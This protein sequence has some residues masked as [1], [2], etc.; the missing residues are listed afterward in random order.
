MW[1]DDGDGTYSYC[2]NDINFNPGGVWPMRDNP[3]SCGILPE[4]NCYTESK[5]VHQVYRAFLNRLQRVFSGHPD[6]ITKAVEMMEALQVHAKK[7]MW[8][9]YRPDDEEDLRTCG[10]VF[11]YEWQ[12]ENKFCMY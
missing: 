9:R 7:L 6:K 2:G 1:V 11:D 12:D 8:T 5:I 3:S 10:P 4:T